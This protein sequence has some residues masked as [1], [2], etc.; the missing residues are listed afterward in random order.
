MCDPILPISRCEASHKISRI[1]RPAIRSVGCTKN[2]LIN[3]LWRRGALGGAS[4]P[5]LRFLRGTCRFV[6]PCIG[7]QRGH[8]LSL[9]VDLRLQRQYV[10]QL[11]TAVLA[12]IPEGEVAN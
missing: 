11:R 5:L 4:D 3:I 7:R 12:D 1:D 9:G 6:F 8:R 10:L 2:E